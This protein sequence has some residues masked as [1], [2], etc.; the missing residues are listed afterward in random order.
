MPGA[1]VPSLETLFEQMTLREVTQMR[2]YAYDVDE[3]KPE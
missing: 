1:T 3:F 2:T